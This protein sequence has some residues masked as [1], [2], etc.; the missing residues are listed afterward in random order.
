M[1]LRF[2]CFVRS[3]WVPG[4][5]VRVRGIEASGLLAG[6]DWIVFLFTVGFGCWV[7]GAVLGVVW[8]FEWRVYCKRFRMYCVMQATSLA[9]LHAPRLT[10]RS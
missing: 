3:G 10:V 5:D 4:S 8:G 7:L 1:M 2:H 9:I 6:L